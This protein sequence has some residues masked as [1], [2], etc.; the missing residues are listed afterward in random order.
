MP[1]K[2][3]ALTPMLE[4]PD[5]GTTINFYTGVLG[6]SVQN[7]MPDMGWASLKRDEI[8]V[9]FALP[10]QH[11]NMGQP[12]MSGSLYIAADNVD[13]IWEEVKEKCM[14]CYPIENFDYGMREFGI[15]DNNGY[16]LQFG[17]EL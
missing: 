14:I 13:E 5:I 2:F 6:F 9:M 8:N 3:T 7:Y 10:N 11:R 4:T 16:L 1:C 17:Q 15:Y 12:V